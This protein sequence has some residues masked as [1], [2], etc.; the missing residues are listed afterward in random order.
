VLSSPSLALLVTAALVS[1]SCSEPARE[2][3]N[4]LVVVID[5]MRA[6]R[7]PFN[8]CKQD[9]APF[10]TEVAAQ[11][12]VFENAFSTC[13]FTAPSTASLFT[14][15]YPFQHAVEAGGRKGTDGNFV[16]NR[17]PD[18]LE[19]LPEMMRA[20][21]YRTFGVVD[22]PTVGRYAGFDRG[23]DEYGHFPFKGAP[24]VN[25]KLGEWIDRIRAPEGA[26]WFV[27]LHYMD[28][29]EPYTLQRDSTVPLSRADLPMQPFAEMSKANR[30]RLLAALK[31]DGRGDPERFAADKL[32]ANFRAYNS[33][34]RFLD[35]HIR[36][37]FDMLGV[38]RDTVVVITADHGEEFGDHGD[39][40]HKF[41]LYPELVRV[42]LVVRWPAGGVAPSRIAAPASLLDVLPTLRDALGEPPNRRDA[43]VSLLPFARGEPM[44]NRVLLTM[45]MQEPDLDAGDASRAQLRGVLRWPDY[46]IANDAGLPPELYDLAA[47]PRAWRDRH[48]EEPALV[49]ELEHAMRSAMAGLPTFERNYYLSEDADPE[50]LERLRELGYLGGN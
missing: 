48:Q 33:Q 42:P 2:L 43:G 12:A 37:A 19:T 17:I 25:A 13:S 16:V 15:L 39:I 46:L 40:S 26:P 36:E 4:V 24:A 18:Q 44:P 34:V 3:P 31:W 21:G 35:G 30:Q 38:D 28:P 41:R 14:G 11:G 23:F 5:T 9:T 7:L 45:R 27:Y 49:A 1:A 8:G 10:L 20:L 50:Y 22:N 6:D 47:D 32:F 29:H